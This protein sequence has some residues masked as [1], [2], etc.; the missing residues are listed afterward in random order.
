MPTK[1]SPGLLKMAQPSKVELRVLCGTRADISLR[2]S[3]L[4]RP[5]TN[6]K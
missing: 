1:N 5:R 2:A 4:V 3:G 6:I